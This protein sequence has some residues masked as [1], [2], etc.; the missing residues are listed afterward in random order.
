[1]SVIEEGTLAASQEVLSYFDIASEQATA[2]EEHVVILPGSGCTKSMN[3]ALAR[4]FAGC[5]Y[6]TLCLDFSGH[7]ESS[8]NFADLTLARRRGQAAALIEACIPAQHPVILA[9]FS[10]SA[11]TVADLIETL[12]DRVAGIVLGAPAVYPRALREVPFGDPSFLQLLSDSETWSD[13]P[14]LAVFSAFRGKTLLLLPECDEQV[15]AAMTELIEQSMRANPWFAKQAVPD[16][17]HGLDEW[18]G[19]HPEARRTLVATFLTASS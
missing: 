8:G 17:D 14:A 2:R 10:M 15:P 3:R 13:S 11:Q 18:F 12:G 1:M 7:G 6:R 19:Q 9:G 5:G 16:A 4:D